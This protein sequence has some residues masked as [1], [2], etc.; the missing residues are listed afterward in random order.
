MLPHKLLSLKY[1]TVENFESIAKLCSENAINLSEFFDYAKNEDSKVETSKFLIR[2][3][4]EV[5]LKSSNGNCSVRVGS[6]T[7]AGTKKKLFEHLENT[8]IFS[9]KYWQNVGEAGIPELIIVCQKL[10]NNAWPI[11]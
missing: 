4:I 9:T 11:R 2:Q 5:Y 10:K 6:D 7:L 1:A 3:N 8:F